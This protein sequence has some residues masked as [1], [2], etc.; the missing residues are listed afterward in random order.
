MVREGVDLILSPAS[1]VPAPYID[2]PPHI[3]MTICYFTLAN[4]VDLPAGT[5]PATTVKEGEDNWDPVRDSGDVDDMLS[6]CI[7]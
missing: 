5:V 2:C 4:I 1:P 6:N 3:F 7:R